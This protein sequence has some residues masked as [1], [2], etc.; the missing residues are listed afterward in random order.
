MIRIFTPS[1]A[2][3]ADTNAQ[4]LSVKEIVSRLAPDRFEVT[5][6]HEAAPDSRIA[7]RRNT[8]LLPWR[9]HANTVRVLSHLVSHVP[10]LYFFP[11]EGPLDAA[12]LK[13]RRFLRLKT[14][15]ISYVVS[16]GLYNGDYP[17]A[18]ANH[19]REATAV[20]DNNSYLGELL[21]ERMGISSAGTM[22]DGIDRRFYFA[23]PEGRSARSGVTVL[24][25]GSLRPYKRVPLVVRAAARWPGV[26]FRIA[27][28]GEEDQLCRRHAVEL[29][30]KNVSFLG[31]LAQ[32]QIGEEMRRAD[33]FFFPSI[34]EG[35]P[36]VLLQAA[37]SGLPIVAM[38]I[39]RPDCVVDG[40]T[41]FLA[42]DD[43]ELYLKLEELIGNRSLRLSMGAAASERAKIFDWD[44][45]SNAWADAFDRVVATSRTNQCSKVAAL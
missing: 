42:G 12:F 32:A 27:G 4:N 10:D 37:G 45:I 9:K 34:L 6:L 15:L 43:Q 44:S 29:G 35:H 7:G 8:I 3:E 33:I 26:S 25:V 28:S 22:Y 19:I 40:S 30:C 39:H 24:Y 23:P 17:Q 14:A 11:R 16:G 31:H 18:R 5:M 20:F 36:Q 41:G 38:R 13:L 2:D 21:R 1:F